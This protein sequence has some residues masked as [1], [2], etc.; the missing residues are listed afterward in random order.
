MTRVDADINFSW[1]EGVDIIP[2]VAREHVSVEWV[3]YLMP[4]QTGAHSFFVEADD[5]V[6]VYVDGELLI[7]SMQDVQDGTQRITS[8]LAPTLEEGKLVPVHVQYYQATGAALIALYW[9]VPDSGGS[10]EIIDSAQL[11]HKAETTAIT[12]ATTLLS[13]RHTPQM[14]T[15]LVQAGSATYE[16]AALT[17]EWQ[18]PADTGCLE[19]LDY[20]VQATLAPEDDDCCWEDLSVGVVGATA[21][22]ADDPDAVAAGAT[23]YVVPGQAVSLRVVARNLLGLGKPSDRTTLDPAALPSGP[24]AVRVTYGADGTLTLD[25]DVPADTGGGDQVAIDPASLVYMLEVDEGFQDGSTGS[26]RFVPLTS[27]DPEGLNPY[28][29]IVFTHESLIVGHTYTYRVKAQNLMGYGAYSPEFQF[30]PRVVP[31]APPLAPRNRPELTTRSTLFVAFDEVLVNGGAAITEYKVYL[32]DGTDSDNYTPYACGTSLTFDTG[33]ADAG[34]PLTLTAG[35]TY[36]AKYSAS[37]VAGE[38]PLSPEVSI[39][40]AERPAAPDSLRR[41]NTQHLPAGHIA[42]KWDAPL[43]EGGSPVTGYT[44]YL[45]GLPYYNTTDADSTLSE[46]TL[47]TLTVGRTHEIAVSAR[48]RI[49]EGAVSSLSLL[50]A[51]LP[52]KLPLL[53]FHSATSSA[54]TVNASSPSYTGGT[55]LT[56]FAYRRDDG[57]LTDYEEQVLQTENL[58]DPRFEFTGLDSAA[59]VYKF[60]IAAVNVLGQGEW[61]DSVSYHATAPPP[62]SESFTVASQST[63]SISVRWTAPAAGDDDC[64]VEGYRV[65]LEDI[66]APGFRVAYDGTRSSTTTAITLRYPTIRPGRYYKLLL[67][68]ANC[69]QVLSTGT[70]LTAASASAPSQIVKA[71]QLQSYD[72]A[73]SMTIAWDDPAYSGGFSVLA[74]KVYVDNNLWEELDPSKNTLQLTGLDLGTQYKVQ[75]TSVNEVGESLPSPSAR[76]TFANRPSPPA[77]LTLTSSALPSISAEWLAPLSANGDAPSGY[78]LYIDNA[79][80]GEEVMAFDGSIGQSA[81]YSWTLSNSIACG[82]TYTLRVTAVNIAG[83]SDGTVGQIKVGDPPSA[84]LHPRRTAITAL[85]SVTIA[86]EDSLSDGCLAVLHHVVNRDGADLPT[87]VE[88]GA[89]SFTDDISVEADFPLGT[90]ITYR[91]KA[92]NAAGASEPSVALTVTVGQVPNAPS[93][94]V[95]SRRFSETSVELQWAAGDAIPANLP[96][97]AFRVYV[98][99]LSGNE[100]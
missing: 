48:N 77:T 72:S 54:I 43:D 98:D 84:P 67:Q 96:T 38:G 41:I 45:D 85:S 15:H 92:V 6:R 70:A 20:T 97:T 44:V 17:I 24:E 12:G 66:L 79:A 23:P 81:T 40:L 63:G 74:F 86:W 65:L 14:A 100:V 88:P 91:V 4:A 52:P 56:A 69:G 21:R 31:A 18:A 99:D 9:S 57:P 1:P 94:V 22:V 3:G 55:P 27:A 30:V 82:A 37:N 33:T 34:G 93:S 83:E 89:N 42:A 39:L 62:N 5:G 46:H 19:V 64:A 68:T 7:D 90:L 16:A 95:V 53:D 76:F 58:E 73:A 13:T 60:Q 50:A 2:G 36:R 71:P 10:F 61:S 11:Y 25:W 28:T 32:D 47:T 8:A 29:A 87:L 80:G 78:R 26:E 35:L 51:S 49:G 75:V 59:R